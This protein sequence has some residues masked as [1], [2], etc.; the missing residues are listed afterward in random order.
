MLLA[1]STRRWWIHATFRLRLARIAEDIKNYYDSYISSLC[2]MA[3]TRCTASALS[4][5]LTESRQ[6]C[7]RDWVSN[8]VSVPSTMAWVICLARW[9]LLLRDTEV[10]F[11]LT[12]GHEAMRH[13]GQRVKA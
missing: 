3:L 7:R 8:P 1:V 4:F 5:M 11:T 10:C 12:E 9:S 2:C 13:Q 6:D